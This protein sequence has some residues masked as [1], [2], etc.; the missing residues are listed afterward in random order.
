MPKREL[1]QSRQVAI[2]ILETLANM[3]GEDDLF[4][5]STLDWYEYEDAVTEILD[6]SDLYG[7]FPSDDE[8][9]IENEAYI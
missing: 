9:L 1:T 3:L 7:I 5:S 4:E 2:S 6:N 8:Y